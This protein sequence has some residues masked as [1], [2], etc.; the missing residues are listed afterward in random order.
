[1]FLEFCVSCRFCHSLLIYQH[2]LIPVTKPVKYRN[3]I[4]PDESFFLAPGNL[5]NAPLNSIDGTTTDFGGNDVSF[6][7]KEY[8][9]TVDV[10]RNFVL[11][12]HSPMH[13]KNFYFFYGRNQIGEER[14]AQ[15]FHSKGYAI[16]RPELLPVETQLN[17]L[18]NCENF[19]SLVGSVSH[20]II[21]L[22]DK[23][24]VI[25]IPRR[26][27]FTNIYQHALNKLHDLNIFYIDSAMS[28]FAPSHT[29]PYCYTISENLRKHFGDEVKIKYTDED[30]V[31]FLAY[32][33]YS[34]SQG[35]KENPNEMKYLEKILP[36][37]IGQL[38]TRKDLMK[39]FGITIN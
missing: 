11:K 21:F 24:N 19:A 28:L 14:I 8:V 32:I 3:I 4:L 13:E 6:F 18:S 26:A 12:N 33:R 23:S 38:K 39:R 25:L 36:E 20:N 17:I 30:L 22:K 5:K 34:Q 15:Y 1:M 16:V 7:T 37:F 31:A 9:E 29:G 2:P 10:I 35:L 27:A